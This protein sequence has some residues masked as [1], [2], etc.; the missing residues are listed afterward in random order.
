[1]TGL[2]GI[3]NLQFDIQS[4]SSTQQ[5]A[6]VPEPSTWAMMLLGFAGLGFMA[7][8]RTKC[9]LEPANDARQH[10]YYREM[11]REGLKS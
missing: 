11:Q 1:M 6:G 10:S 2:G 9:A 4:V 8:S 5:V 3:E 7:R